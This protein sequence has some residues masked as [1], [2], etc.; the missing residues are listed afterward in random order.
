M[1]LLQLTT[2]GITATDVA[3]RSVTSVVGLDSPTLLPPVPL[4]FNN[5]LIMVRN[6]GCS[7][8]YII[9]SATSDTVSEKYAYN[10]IFSSGRIPQT[11]IPNNR[12][13]GTTMKT[14]KEI[15]N[16]TAM[17]NRELRNN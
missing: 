13:N 14:R 12:R 7:M 6:G 10:K 5:S 1:K 11:F 9:A 16:T 3:I 2:F 8:T 15:I 17:K 4:E